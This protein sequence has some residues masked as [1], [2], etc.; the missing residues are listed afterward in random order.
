MERVLLWNFSHRGGAPFAYLPQP[1]RGA[2]RYNKLGDGETLRDTNDENC[3]VRLGHACAFASWFSLARVGAAFIRRLS[4]PARMAASKCSRLTQACRS[5][6][7]RTRG[8][9]IPVFVSTRKARGTHSISLGPQP[10]SRSWRRAA[11]R[12]VSSSL[13]N[14]SVGTR[15]LRSRGRNA[16]LAR[17]MT[18]EAMTRRSGERRCLDIPISSIAS[19]G[20]TST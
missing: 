16:P 20:L 7:S 8:R 15:R 10:C 6:S 17:S 11:G 3:T 12:A 4:H 9:S 13:C 14:S 18:C 1:R 5:R 2:A 19:C